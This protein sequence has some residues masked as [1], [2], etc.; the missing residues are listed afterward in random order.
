ML[1]A[2]C[3]PI[4]R[5]TVGTG[6]GHGVAGMPG[7]QNMY[8]TLQKRHFPTSLEADVHVWIELTA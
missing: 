8:V 1:G 6:W 2:D 3:D 4:A 7:V 5:Q